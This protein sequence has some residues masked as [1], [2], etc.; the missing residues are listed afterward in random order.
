M[1][2]ERKS[3]VPGHKDRGMQLAILNIVKMCI[4]FQRGAMP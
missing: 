4:T 1:P 2:R 3:S